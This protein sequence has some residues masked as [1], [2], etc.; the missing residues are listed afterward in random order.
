[1]HASAS[2]SNAS[3]QATTSDFGDEES[4][5]SIAAQQVEFWED[6]MDEDEL[7]TVRTVASQLPAN[8][9]EQMIWDIQSLVSC[10][11]SKADQLLGKNLNI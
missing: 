9:S 8:L 10:L 2:S 1:M 11:I 7:Q 5:A 6:A 3:T 4:L